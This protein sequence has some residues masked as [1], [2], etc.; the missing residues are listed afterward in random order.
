MNFEEC[1]DIPAA[2]SKAIADFNLQYGKI[3]KR[4]HAALEFTRYRNQVPVDEFAQVAEQCLTMMKTT[5]GLVSLLSGARDFDEYFFQ[6]M[7]NVGLLAGI[8]AKWSGADETQQREFIMAGL[9]HDVGK[10]RIPEELLNKPR[11]LEREEM[12]FVRKHTQLGVGLLER[13]GV[14]SATILNAAEQHHERIDSSGYPYGLPGKEISY[15]GRVVAVADLYVAM[16]SNRAYRRSVSPFH[17]METLSDD[18][19]GK[20]DPE[21]CALFLHNIY[22]HLVGSSV[23]LNNGVQAKIIY[24]DKDRHK[25]PVVATAEGECVDLNQERELQIAEILAT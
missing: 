2:D 8:L 22:D 1:T 13:S 15:V 17:V 12:A 9:L 16:T 3:V 18:M 11:L 10:T 5:R 7:V 20:L 19:Y 24:V 4:V 6:H 21:I 23:L 25:Q 14:T